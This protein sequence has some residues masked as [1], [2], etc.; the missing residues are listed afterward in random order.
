MER[1]LFGQV[2]TVILPDPVLCLRK[3]V[4]VAGLELIIGLF[5][6]ILLGWPYTADYLIHRLAT[7][8]ITRHT[9][10]ALSIGLV[11]LLS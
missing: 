3:Q 5:L 2:A 11:K 1:F 7:Y 10:L 8:S 4:W 9:C 6:D